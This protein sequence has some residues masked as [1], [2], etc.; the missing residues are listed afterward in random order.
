MTGLAVDDV[1]LTGDSLFLESV[2]RPDLEAG[3]D[4]APAFARE[5]YATVTERLAA[6]GDATVIAPGHASERT[7]RSDDRTYTATLG[8]LRDRLWAFEVDEATF[9]DRVCSNVPPRPANVDAILAANLGE[10]DPDD[11][12]A[13]AWELGPNNCAATAD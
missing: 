6:F 5:L 2:A 10:T 3:D 12:E 11:D 9:V 4:D 13:F 7:P 8:T 1:L